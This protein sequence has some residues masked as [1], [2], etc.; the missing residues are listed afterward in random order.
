MC[1]RKKYQAT[2]RRTDVFYR[3]QAPTIRDM[4]H[5]PP[6]LKSTLQMQ[7]TYR[8][9]LLAS[10]LVWSYGRHIMW[11]VLFSLSDIFESVKLLFYFF[12]FFNL[13]HKTRIYT[14]GLACTY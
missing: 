1:I 8:V 3:S 9:S 10:S 12:V 5:Y 13:G 4:L 7:R 11:P 2:C 14:V 6:L